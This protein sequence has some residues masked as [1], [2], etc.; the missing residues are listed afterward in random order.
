MLPEDCQDKR[1]QVV[2]VLI[3]EGA[4]CFIADHALPGPSAVML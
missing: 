2:L 4:D 3:T 1:R